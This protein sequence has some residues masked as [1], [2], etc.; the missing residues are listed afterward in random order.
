MHSECG[1]GCGFRPQRYGATPVRTEPGGSGRNKLR[2]VNFTWK[3]NRVL[4]DALSFCSE[5]ALRAA[6]VAAALAAACVVALIVSSARP[7]STV[8]SQY[9]PHKILPLDGDYPGGRTGIPID[10]YPEYLGLDTAHGVTPYFS[11][12]SVVYNANVVDF[13]YGGAA[14][15][16]KRAPRRQQVTVLS[17]LRRSARLQF[18]VAAL[19]RGL[20]HQA[21]AQAYGAGGGRE[22]GRRRIM[23]MARPLRRQQ[24]LAFSNILPNDWA[25][26]VAQGYDGEP[27]VDYPYMKNSGT[28]DVLETEND[29]VSKQARYPYLQYYGQA[30]SFDHA[31][32]IDGTFYDVSIAC[33]QRSC[34]AA[35]APDLTHRLASPLLPPLHG[36]FFQLPCVHGGCRSLL[37]LLLSPMIPVSSPCPVLLY[38]TALLPL[39]SPSPLS[40]PKSK[41]RREV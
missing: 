19:T 30:T 15:R 7:S 12:P 11:D 6:R 13:P 17:H 20:R 2:A 25:M 3:E 16:S 39:L 34:I 37:S 26:P 9:P 33:L 41:S 8:L 4:V 27:F 18:W 32:G 14:A 24:Q 28:A 1:R 22:M 29:P 31:N 5:M 38:I 40:P 10:S 35:H 23:G 21:L 36:S